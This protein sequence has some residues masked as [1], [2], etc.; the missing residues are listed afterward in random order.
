MTVP[1]AGAGVVIPVLNQVEYTIGCLEGLRRHGEGVMNVVV[2]DNG[3]TDGTEEELSRRPDVTVIRN[4]VNLGCAA[5]WNQGVRA[6]GSEWIAILNNDVIL[7][8][9]WL[10]GLLAFAEEEGADIVSPAIREGPKEYDVEE[11]AR[12]FVRRMGKVARR[13]VADGICFLVRRRV[14]DTIG[15]FDENFRIGQFEDVDFFRR[16]RGAGF[17]LAITGR[18]FIHHFGSITQDSLRRNR[19]TRPYE[20]ENREYYRE[21]WGLA[22]GGRLRE[23]VGRKSREFV[24][25]WSERLLHGRTLKERW[26]GGRLLRG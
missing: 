22:R 5:A 21:K 12:E 24:W 17:R 6:V 15:Y 4:P 8:P 1:P 18:S 19:A 11:Y 9:G 10:P 7:T 3:S 16:A 14:F 25:R 26:I 23:R 13:G 2:V 20:A